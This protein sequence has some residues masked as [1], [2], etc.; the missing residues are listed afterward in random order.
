MRRAWALSILLASGSASAQAWTPPAGVGAATLGVQWLRNT[1]H[2]L[3]DGSAADLRGRS[4]NATIFVEAD[5]GLT[6]RL[7]ATAAVAYVFAKYTDPEPTPGV[8][9]PV[10][11]CRCW[12]SSF[13]DF[14][15]SARYR[16]GDDP[17]ALTP[18][19]RLVAPS[20][21][22]ETR[23]EAVVGRNLRELHVGAAAAWRLADLLPR[24]TVQASYAYVFAPRVEGVALDRSNV[25]LGLGY[26]VTRRIYLHVDARRQVTHGGVRA[27]SPSADPFPL[28]EFIAHFDEHDRLLRDDATRVGGGISYSFGGFDAFLSFEMLAHGTD[29]HDNQAVTAGLT[30]Y[31]GR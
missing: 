20:H 26:A 15:F 31:F 8:F 27:G 4:V 5:Y 19:I 24:A 2:L 23:G 30:Y 14:T 9:L 16:L 17:W 29:T 1:G 28:P 12:N 11:S 6:G 3:T 13:Q 21:P 7:A 22:Y 10:D 25:F 18:L